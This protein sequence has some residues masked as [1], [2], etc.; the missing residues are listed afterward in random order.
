MNAA[1]PPPASA[2]ASPTRTCSPPSP[3]YR[4]SDSRLSARRPE[5]GR[6][7]P[8]PA[9]KRRRLR[10]RPAAPAPV[11]LGPGSRPAAKS[12]SRWPAPFSIG[13]WS[14]T[15]SLRRPIPQ[16]SPLHHRRCRQ[17][18]RHIVVRLALAMQPRLHA[19]L[20]H[21][22]A[23]PTMRRSVSRSLTGRRA[24]SCAALSQGGG[25]D[26]APLC[27][28]LCHRAAGPTM[29]RSVSRS[30]TGRR[31]R[32]CAALSQ[33]GGPALPTSS[34]TMSAPGPRM[35]AASPAI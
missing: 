9:E 16:L 27:Q 29:R 17:Q 35:S 8:G 12:A 2:P 26:H 11:R 32:S 4:P 34:S 25:P 7:R 5:H 6:I 19:P 1:S 20:C 10:R 24:R 28:P 23:G 31:A 30:L 21:R 15:W 3:P 33:G 13:F 14:A 22:A 18:V